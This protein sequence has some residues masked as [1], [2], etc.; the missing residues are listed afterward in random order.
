MTTTEFIKALVEIFSSYQVR[1]ED[2]GN[3]D[4]VMINL[5]HYV[6][7]GSFAF[8]TEPLPDIEVENIETMVSIYSHDH[9]FPVTNTGFHP[10][11]QETLD[12]IQSSI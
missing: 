11:S 12:M 7:L 2:N 8:Y 9:R 5:N 4:Y 10:I 6:H 1:V 3:W